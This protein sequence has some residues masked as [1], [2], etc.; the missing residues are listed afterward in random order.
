MA[1]SVT[2]EPAAKLSF[3]ENQ[4][5]LDEHQIPK[6]PF[7]IRMAYGQALEA[8][9]VI[10]A[11]HN[12]DTLLDEGY[13]ETF[14]EWFPNSNQF[15]RFV[16]RLG[17]CIL[18]VMNGLRWTWDKNVLSSAPTNTQSIKNYFETTFKRAILAPEVNP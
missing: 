3:S 1:K 9:G 6:T 12:I 16:S 8:A 2:K 13:Q 11:M 4:H 5:L 15:Q 18:Q 7:N 14:Q 17:V 10:H